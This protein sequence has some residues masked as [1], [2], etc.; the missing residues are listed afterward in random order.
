M[1]NRLFSIVFLCVMLMV[2]PVSLFAQE[3][4]A[5]DTLETSGAR[6]HP[7]R[8]AQAPPPPAQ[9]AKRSDLEIQ[10]IT[11]SANALRAFGERA[12]SLSIL[13]QKHI[14]DSIAAYQA[15]QKAL[16]EKR[17]ID[18]IAA[19]VK[20]LADSIAALEARRKADSVAA[21]QAAYLADSLAKKRT[22]DSLADLE[23]QRQAYLAKMRSLLKKGGG[24]KYKTGSAELNPVIT[25]EL[26]KFAK[27]LLEYPHLTLHIIGYTDD[28]GKEATN[29]KL[30]LKRAET[31][32]KYL[33]KKG[34][35]E[36]RVTTESKGEA[37]PIVPND[38]KN[39]REINRRV[40]FAVNGIPE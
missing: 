11:D 18:S 6:L 36:T 1:Q 23:A 22:A 34:V 21:Y 27:E 4:S 2:L 28:V 17:R 26:D 25:E 9:P 40:E 8:P 20:R 7:P 19:H 33:V 39:N 12:D 3:F 14:A 10:R 31:A 30:G 37:D 13:H 38:S 32:K 29:L 35:A 5:V 16:A 24:G 15:M